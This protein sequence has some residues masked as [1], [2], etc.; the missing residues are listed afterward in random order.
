MNA[1]VGVWVKDAVRP[2]FNYLETRK[3]DDID[4]PTLRQAISS[5]RGHDVACV[6]GVMLHPIVLGTKA[7]YVRGGERLNLY[8]SR[9]GWGCARH[10]ER[11]T[12]VGPSE[13][14]EY[15]ADLIRLGWRRLPLQD[16]QPEDWK[17]HW[18]AQEW[19]RLAGVYPS[20]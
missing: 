20:P 10:P 1:V 14:S 17:P 16:W 18:T 5:L 11:D 8:M 13:I 4:D 12:L 6:H 15:S 19:S 9:N 7:V 3:V 2:Q